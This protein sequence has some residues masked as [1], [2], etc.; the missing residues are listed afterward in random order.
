MLW[1]FACN[2][3]DSGASGY[4]TTNTFNSD[5][6]KYYITIKKKFKLLFFIPDSDVSE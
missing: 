6:G 3:S 1:W 4:L 2:I 5:I